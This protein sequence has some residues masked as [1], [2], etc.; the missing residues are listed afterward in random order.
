MDVI[1]LEKVDRLGGLGDVVKVKAGFARNYLLPT[2]KAKV[3]TEENIKALEER[4]AE[5]EAR[6][7]EQLA[8]AQARKAKLD[9]LAVTIA[10]QAGTEGKLFGSIGTGDIADAVTAAGV[11]VE[12]KEVRM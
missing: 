11:D 5:L 12:K 1:L 9:G 7:A 4:R 6:A 2:G 8:A 10:A 3:A